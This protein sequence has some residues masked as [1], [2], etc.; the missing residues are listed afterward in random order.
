MSTY[1]RFV[2]PAI[3][4][5]VLFY[6]LFLFENGM[7]PGIVHS[8]L[9]FFYLN[10]APFFCLGLAVV[11]YAFVKR[12][13]KPAI[14]LCMKVVCGL[15]LALFLT[16]FFVSSTITQI[17]MGD[18]QKYVKWQMP[19]DKYTEVIDWYGAIHYRPMEGE[20]ESG[21]AGAPRIPDIREFA[22]KAT[23]RYWISFPEVTFHKMEGTPNVVAVLPIVAY[24]GFPIR[25]PYLDG[26]VVV[27]TDEA[28]VYSMEQL[29][30]GETVVTKEMGMIIP[31][32]LANA[33][34]RATIFEKEGI[35]KGMLYVP[36]QV[37]Q[38]REM[39]LLPE[40]SWRFIYRDLNRVV[41]ID[42]VTGDVSTA[43][44]GESPMCASIIQD[45]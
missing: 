14:I 11:A 33:L 41:E 12:L 3:L 9:M 36:S 15:M 39:S 5:I 22:R 21:T 38:A 40:C 37:Q 31:L 35:V 6:V 17:I 27:D 32:D 19:D 18:N 13:K 20:Y 4:V 24:R 8:V 2:A 45:Q 7:V 44:S 28:K 30:R 29:R 16:Y 25:T 1:R 26:V 42:S 23:N 43:T 34:C 10:P